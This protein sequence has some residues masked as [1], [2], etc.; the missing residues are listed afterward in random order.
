MR[1]GGIEQP[2]RRFPARLPRDNA[3][4]SG[5]A[6]R[7]ADNAMR[8]HVGAIPDACAHAIHGSR[9][10]ADRLQPGQAGDAGAVF[11]DAGI[12]EDQRMR[13]G[14][15]AEEGG[16]D[17]AVR[18]GDKNL[19]ADVAKRRNAVG[20]HDLASCAQ[21]GASLLSGVSPVKERARRQ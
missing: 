5:V 15:R 17:A 11:A 8:Q 2:F 13:A 20:D 4:G 1:R 18:T 3:A 6:V 14:V 7:V 10:H 16:N 12:V 9:S 19:A 21:G